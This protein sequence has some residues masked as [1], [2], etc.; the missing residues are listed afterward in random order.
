MVNDVNELLFLWMA[1]ID[2]SAALSPELSQAA[3]LNETSDPLAP[4]LALCEK[5]RGWAQP[6]AP[7][8]ALEARLRATPDA[9]GPVLPGETGPASLPKAGSDEPRE[10]SEVHGALACFQ[11]GV[12]AY[13]SGQL[14]RAIEWLERASR[15]EGG[16]NYWYQFLLG[17]LEDK[18]GYTEDA[19]RNYSVAVALVAPATRR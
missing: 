8:V 10:V 5:V 16:K 2:E 14:A 7:W 17:F 3:G 15:L 11:W 6:K 13:R 1:A 12:L 19:F 9:A 4:A 18:A